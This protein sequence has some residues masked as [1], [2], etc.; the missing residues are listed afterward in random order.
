MREARRL[1]S[2]IHGLRGTWATAQRE[3]VRRRR[4]SSSFP[5]DVNVSL[6]RAATVDARS[7]QHALVVIAFEFV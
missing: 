3:R 1:L 2:T 6:D 4:P 7:R 5:R